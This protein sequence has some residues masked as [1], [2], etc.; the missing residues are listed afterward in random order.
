MDANSC[1]NMRFAAERRTVLLAVLLLVGLASICPSLAAQQR[2]TRGSISTRQDTARVQDLIRRSREARSADT[3][4]FRLLADS[5]LLLARRGTD[6][7]VLGNALLLRASVD[8]GQ[9]RNAEGLK[10]L[11]ECVSVCEQRPDSV[12]LMT[13]LLVIGQLSFQTAETD[14]A[15]RSFQRAL[16]IAMALKDS[17]SAGLMQQWLGHMWQWKGDVTKSMECYEQALRLYEAVENRAGQAWT[18]LNVGGMHERKR[19]QET[20]LR[21]YRQGLAIAE[22][23]RDTVRIALALG[24]IGICYDGLERY[25]E[26]VDYLERA[27]ELQ[28]R[29]PN[30]GTVAHTLGMLGAICNKKKD[31]E[32][33][34]RYLRRSVA[35]AQ[36][37]GDLFREGRAWHGLAWAFQTRGELDSALYYEHIAL[38]RYRTGG[39][40]REVEYTWRTLSTMH[41]LAGRY[42]EAGVCL[43][44]ALQLATQ[45][46]ERGRIGAV[47]YDIAELAEKQGDFKRAYEQFRKYA[48]QQDSVMSQ[49]SVEQI[50]EL[51]VRYETDKKDQQISLLEKDK[52]IAE[53]ELLR[54]AEELEHHRLLGM[55]HEQELEMLAQQREIQDLTLAR[56]AG[57]LSLSQSQL[58]LNRAENIRKQQELDLQ[59]S[60]LSSET[61]L[62][63]AA[64]TGL[65]LAVLLAV[66]V[67][68][69]LRDKR[70]AEALRASTAEY[71]AQAAAAQAEAAEARALAAKAE[72]ERRAKEIQ[73]AFARELIDSQ[74]KE[75]KRIAGSLH[76][77]IGQDLLI[78][79]HRA[80]MALEE[81]NGNASHLEDILEV[82]AEAIDDVR[83]I[84]RD[85]RPYQLERVGL[86]A[87]LRSMIRAVD[88]STDLEIT[89]DVADIDG[90]IAPEREIDLYRIVQEA[91]NNILKHADARRVQVRIGRMNGSIHLSVRDDGRGFDADAA[92]DAAGSGLGLQGMAER[93]RML[94]GNLA[95]ESE[96]GKG[97]LLRASFPVKEPESVHTETRDPEMA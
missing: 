77:G 57:E 89:D 53:L 76:D 34:E 90:L 84:S 23:I 71:Q 26:A 96:A 88:E 14:R 94:G 48:V 97:T 21:Y 35:I 43:D 5:A 49:R 37:T 30:R 62:R 42:D 87:T 54:R 67:V 66:F 29:M 81:D 39:R 45:L 4:R 82:S 55:Q 22:E 40:A 19:D 16:P 86:T 73:E 6:T 33:G 9:K 70:R 83:R 60:R 17:S 32:R 25:D 10:Y 11:E 41:Q 63:N 51:T 15:I 65:I 61:L 68:R 92:R 78:I 12:P 2:K 91:L 85:L 80:M 79:K 20:A 59:A 95:I 64:V 72:A 18:L 27:L 8:Y 38:D 46:N 24:T 50:N 7:R 52:R 47:H 1:I 56:Q 44:S 69:S 75:R 13:A 31:H 36:E 3:A 58:A 93:V 28:E 74:E